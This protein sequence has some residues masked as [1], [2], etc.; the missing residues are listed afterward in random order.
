M[1]IF[2]ILL[3]V[4][5]AIAGI[6]LVIMRFYIK[7]SSSK[8]NKGLVK[9]AAVL[10]VV[11]IVVFVFGC[12]FVIVPTGYT[13]VRTTFGQVSQT[14]MHQGFNWKIPFVENVTLVNNKQQDTKSNYDIWGETSEKTPVYASD[15]VVTFQISPERSSWLYANVT[16]VNNLIESSLLASA[17]KSAM[18]ELPAESVTNRTLI[19]PLVQTY[20]QMSLNSKFGS[21]TVTVLKVSIN[22]MDFEESYNSAIA[23]RSIAR[24]NYE[25]QLIENETAISKA[26]AEKQVQITNA[27]AKAE[28]LLIAAQAEADANNL[29]TKSLTA[30][31]LR[32]K[33]YEKWDGRMPAVMG[34]GS[35]ITAI[36]IP[37]DE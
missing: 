12:S 2:C 36:E 18:V 35:N 34:T 7:H 27:E 16:N 21:D 31:V 11:G 3:G 25:K 32:A 33:F 37:I 1:N 15:I 14:V 19:E 5:A 20:L 6:V 26:E 28:A 23:A 10:L 24:Q 30:E 29:L 4:I 9:T 8:P 22:Q 17:V 13:G